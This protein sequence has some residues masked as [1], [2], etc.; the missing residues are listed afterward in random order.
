MWPV[1]IFFLTLA[2][3]LNGIAA[4][5]P[6]TQN[7]RINQVQLDQIAD[8]CQ[9]QNR[10]DKMCEALIQLREIGDDAVEAVKNFANL[11]PTEYALLTAVNSI[12]NGR[13]R[14][15]TKARFFGNGADTLDIHKQ[16]V[17][18]IFE[19]TF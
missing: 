18:L 7:Q 4:E 10:K 11:T 5:D 3:A 9:R 14:V 16:T 15:R 13:V 17:A 19:R 1:W 12:A 2:L 8:A 6:T